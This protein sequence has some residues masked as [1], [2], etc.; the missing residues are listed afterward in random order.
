MKL[1]GSF[2]M[3][4]KQYAKGDEVPWYTIY[5]F[6]AIHM[7]AFGASGFFMAY[8]GQVDDI[9]FLY[10][11]GGVAIFAYS[12]FYLVVF[13]VDAVIWMFINAALGLFGIYSQ[14]DWILSRFGK[15]A[16]DFAVHVHAIPFLYYV[17]YTFLLRQ[18]VLDITRSREGSRRKIVDVL[19]VVVSLSV[20][21]WLNFA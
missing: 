8:G 15:S 3:N 17:L 18:A 9:A 16:E 6:F 19:Y 12:V 13:G 7:L 5:P 4:G 14:I 20:Y 21:S 10:M 11:H 1:H 2:S